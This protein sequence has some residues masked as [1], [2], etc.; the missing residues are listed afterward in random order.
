MAAL[1]ASSL[2]REE[3]SLHWLFIKKVVPKA[4][5]TGGNDDKW[6]GCASGTRYGSSF[7]L[8]SKGRGTFPPRPKFNAEDR[9]IYFCG[10]CISFHGRSGGQ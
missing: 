9:V 10:S 4:H 6:R 3:P 5:Y 2:Y 1:A 8:S 7:L